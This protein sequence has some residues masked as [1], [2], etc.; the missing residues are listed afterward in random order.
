M[1]NCLM[2]LIL[3]L[4]LRAVLFNGIVEIICLFDPLIFTISHLLYYH[5]FQLMAIMQTST[6][7]YSYKL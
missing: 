6:V 1:N 3:Y 5:R 2:I 7:A 4:C